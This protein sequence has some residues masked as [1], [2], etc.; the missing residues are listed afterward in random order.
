MTRFTSGRTFAKAIHSAR[1][2]YKREDHTRPPDSARNTAA[3]GKVILI[4]VNS[5]GLVSTSIEPTCCLT[6]MSWLIERPRPVP[7]PAGLV[8]KKGLN[9]FSFTSGG[10]P[11]PLSRILISTRSPRFLVAT[12]SVGS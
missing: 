7:S 9:I 6:T 3:R 1:S 5:P 10:I 11:V 8:V 4:S 12:A 2:L